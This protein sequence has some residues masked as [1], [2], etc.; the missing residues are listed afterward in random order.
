VFGDTKM[1]TS[2]LDRLTHRCHI[3]ETAMT[4]SASGQA[5]KRRKHKRKSLSRDHPRSAGNYP[6][7]GSLLNDNPGSI[8]S[9]NQQANRQVSSKGSERAALQ[10]FLAKNIAIHTNCYSKR[11][12]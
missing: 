3:L 9:D 10:T 11:R 8:T 6:S 5:L 2:L 4:A 1:T 7:G 12:I